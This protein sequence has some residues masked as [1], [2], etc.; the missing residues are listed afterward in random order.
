[1]GLSMNEK[2]KSTGKQSS[3]MARYRKEKY[4]GDAIVPVEVTKDGIIIKEDDM[5]LD[6]PYPIKYRNTLYLLKKVAEHRIAIFEE[7]K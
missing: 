3:S 4:A 1:M 2:D 6:K 7:V 5:L